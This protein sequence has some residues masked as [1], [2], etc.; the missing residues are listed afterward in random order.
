MK[1][2]QPVEVLVRGAHVWPLSLAAYHALGEA[3]LIP[4]RTELLYG[5]V[6]H[7]M[8]K[9]P[10]HSFLLQFLQ[11]ILLRAVSPGHHQQPSLADPNL[12]HRTFRRRGMGEDLAKL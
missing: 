3:G 1:A 11:E 6:Y 2:L 8:S 12:S 4:K 5:F 7:K 9:S 10:F